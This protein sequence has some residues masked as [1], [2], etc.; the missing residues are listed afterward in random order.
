MSPSL[1]RTLFP[2]TMTWRIARL[3][4]A[5]FEPLVIS[6]ELWKNC[7]IANLNLVSNLQKGGKQ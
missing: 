5:M 4:K 2:M 7:A 6:C 3:Q 1:L